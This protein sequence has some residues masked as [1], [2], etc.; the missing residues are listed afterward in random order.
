MTVY[1]NGAEF[2]LRRRKISASQILRILWN[3]NFQRCV[4]KSRSFAPIMS[5][6]TVASILP[7]YFLQINFDTMRDV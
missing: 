2:P 5:Q 7:F 3:H 1:L 6:M 4:K